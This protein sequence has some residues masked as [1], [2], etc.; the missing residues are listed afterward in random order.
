MSDG[1][2]VSVVV[3]VANDFSMSADVSF[4]Y[5]IVGGDGLVSGD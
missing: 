2:V 3:Q 4:D 5:Q 1:D